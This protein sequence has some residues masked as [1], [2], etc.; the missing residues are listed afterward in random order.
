VDAGQKP[1]YKLSIWDTGDGMTGEETVEYINH[2]ASSSGELHLLP[3]CS[4]EG[5]RGNPRNHA[6]ARKQGQNVPISRSF[7][8]P[9]RSPSRT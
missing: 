8:P 2:L 9:A 5:L 3:I 7:G 1:V 6:N 4:P